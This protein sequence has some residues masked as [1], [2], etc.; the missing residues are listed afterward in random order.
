[1]QIELAQQPTVALAVL[2]HRM[3]PVVFEDLYERTYHD[4]A[5]KVDL[6]TS[7]DA[8][9]SNA[10]DMADSVAWKALEDEREKWAQRLPKRVDALLAWLLQ[11]DQDVMS[12]LFAFCV[13][14]T[15]DG[16]SAA[17]RPHA[18]N[19]IANTLGV[20]FTRYWKPTRAAYFE[21]VSKDRIASI[22]GEVVSPR[23]AGELR[24]MKKADAATAAELRMA[25]SGWLPEVLRNREVPKQVAYGHWD[26]DDEDSD[27]DAGP[28]ADA[29]SEQADDGQQQQ[30]E[31][32]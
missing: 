27:Q 19:E 12:N 18:V 16:I 7:R 24:G 20:D 23:S 10:D 15:V 32:T 21:H 14:A 29:T 26:N 31:A 25:D 17:D 2:M 1:V 22:V 13:A 8:L 9:L 6:Q 4:R 5:V 28:D 30:A 3:I 11:Q